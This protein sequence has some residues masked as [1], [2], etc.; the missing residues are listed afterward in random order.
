MTSEISNLN[1]ALTSTIQALDEF[2]QIEQLQELVKLA[3]EQ[4]D[5]KQNGTERAELLTYIYLKDSQ[6]WVISVRKALET[7]QSTLLLMKGVKG[8]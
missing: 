1:K 2:D 8:D 5:N 7:I 6:D 4:F 3:F